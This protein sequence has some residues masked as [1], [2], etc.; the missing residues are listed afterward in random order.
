MRNIDRLKR[1]LELL[2]FT[3]LA[4]IAT[5]AILIYLTVTLPHKWWILLTALIVS[6][7][8]HPGLI[9]KRS[10]F[11]IKGTFTALILLIPLLYLVQLNYRL[12]SIILVLSLI[13]LTVSSLNIKR[14]D[15]TV[16]FITIFAFFL[17]AISNIPVTPEEP[18]EM[19]LNRGI[20]TVI[21]VSIVL[22]TDYFLFNSFQYSQKLYFF[23]Q[24]L[25]HDFFS[26]ELR[27]LKSQHIK[28]RNSFL[29]IQK[30]R[31][32]C[33]SLF[34][35]INL[36]AENLQAELKTD[37]ALKNKIS[38]YMDDIWELR[39]VLFATSYSLLVLKSPK[40]SQQQME[41]F[42]IQLKKIK[43]YFV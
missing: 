32:E 17:T 2:R 30:L 20:C 9:I 15:I 1:K 28:S 23:H 13:G 19:V 8:I 11:R 5:A 3:H 43:K 14:Y 31:A 38:L 18:F 42:E 41:Q 21:G 40:I 12:I 25:I 6:A 35:L 33:N 7:G 27:K 22:L 39:R 10:L 29:F 26:R 24:L 4:I 36:S 34:I 37:D 16:F